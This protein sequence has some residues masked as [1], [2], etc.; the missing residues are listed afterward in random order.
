MYEYLRINFP[1]TI[2]AERTAPYKYEWKIVFGAMLGRNIKICLTEIS[3]NRWTIDAFREIIHEG[4]IINTTWLL[5][6]CT[7]PNK[8][9]QYILDEI[10]SWLN[11][12]SNYKKIDDEQLDEENISKSNYQIIYGRIND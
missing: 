3:E 5:Y 12:F 6:T 11:D 10:G 9:G 1:S 7:M 4:R 2:E 8:F